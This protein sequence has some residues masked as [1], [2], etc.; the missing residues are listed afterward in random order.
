MCI[1]LAAGCLHPRQVE[2]GDGRVCPEG[3][4]CVHLDTY[5][6]DLCAL[7]EQLAACKDHNQFAECT[8][9]GMTPARCYDGVC[10]PGG[11]GNGR[12]DPEEACDDGNNIVG[13]GCAADC[14]SDETCGNGRLD[15]VRGEQCDDGDLIGHDGC[16]SGCVPEPARWAPTSLLSPFARRLHGMAFDVDRR[17]VVLFGG[18]GGT[19][20]EPEVFADT[21]EYDERGWRQITPPVAPQA[22]SGAAMAYD[23]AH[24]RVVLFGGLALN[25]TWLWDGTSWTAVDTPVAPPVGRTTQWTM[26]YDSGRERIVIVGADTMPKQT[27]EFDGTTWARLAD[28]PTTS[29]FGQ[30]N[31][32]AYDPSRGRLVLVQDNGAASKTSEFDG[33]AWVEKAEQMPLLG[34]AALAYDPI[35]KHVLAVG[36]ANPNMPYTS[37]AQTWSWDGQSWSRIADPP[38]NFE[39]GVAVTDPFTPAVIEFGGMLSPSLGALDQTL[40]WN[41]SQW[42][43]LPLRREPGVP[44]YA[45]MA[46]DPRRGRAVLY[47][48]IGRLTWILD[49]Y[50]W[51]R[52]TSQIAVR[53]LQAM[54]YDDARDELVMFGGSD[55][56]GP[57]F[58]ETWRWNGTWTQAS[59]AT[60]PSARIGAAMTYD[61]VAKRLVLFGGVTQPR[62]NPTYVSET[63]TWDG[64]NWT[65]VTPATNLPP[66]RVAPAFAYDP[67][68]QRAVLFGGSGSGAPVGDTWEWDGTQW[69]QRMSVVG[70]AARIGA[71]LTWD[72][73][74]RRLVLFGG[75]NGA[76]FAPI[77]YSDTWEWDGTSWQQL[78]ITGPVLAEHRA[79]TNGDSGVFITATD[80]QNSAG[81]VTYQLRRDSANTYEACRTQIDAD[82][83]GAV[84]CADLDCWSVCSP[85]CPP[86]GACDPAAPHCG[87]GACSSVESCTSCSADCGACPTICG[88][89]ACNGGETATSCPGDC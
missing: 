53:G 17:T 31:G 25:D 59:P 14:L 37:L 83:D 86:G 11:C 15:P 74:R 32:L 18:L 33:T 77:I 84:G 36:L 35:T 47:D 12:Q 19:S 41:G 3:F 76:T 16:A 24:H 22:R 55:P 46:S 44:M 8:L 10:L 72:A 79:F 30:G 26:A 64:T 73:A 13:D 28:A 4:E 20:T 6:Q 45:T 38:T 34:K 65:N 87:D 42:Q 50:T 56:N 49:G 81:A 67:V 57:D 60:H 62:T 43:L 1:L 51:Q 9:A 39:A 52:M 69:T 61:P 71:S 89:G 88:D 63:W 5:D 27:W 29:G 82:G 70:P 2:C 23:A 21:W 85:L 54:A 80:P 48:S 75:N 66:G 68:R 78:P 58:D 7:P 40:T